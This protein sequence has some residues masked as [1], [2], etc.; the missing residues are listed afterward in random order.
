MTAS[1]L[2][3]H[4][5][6]SQPATDHSSGAALAPIPPPPALAPL[7]GELPPDRNPAAVYLARLAP[8]SRRTMKGAL[9]A[10]AAFVAGVTAERLPW[11]ALRYPH[12]AAI[13]AH[14]AATYAAS[15]ANKMLAALR[16]VLGEAFRLGLM[17]AEDHARASAVE[18]VRGQTVPKGRAVTSGELR[19]LFGACDG[20]SP[21]A[22][23][24][25]AMLAV[26]YGA[27][28]RRAEVA[29]LTRADANGETGALIVRGKGNKERVAY[30]P[31]G[32]LE[33]VGAWLR[34]RGDAPGPLFCPI[35]KGGRIVLRH[36]TEQGVYLALRA[37]ATR[38]GVASFSPH[39][40]R[41]TFIGDLL[42]AGADIATVQRLAGHSSVNTTA[43]YDR[44]GERVKQKAAELL[45]V[46]FVAPLQVPLRAG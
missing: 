37:L 5:P 31:G 30:A 33:A 25:A 18:G 41:R 27:G 40:M 4:P 38:A 2:S 28:L 9:D 20:A 21:I 8:G 44:R 11:Q 45:H 15:T 23:R 26:F 17:T 7:A 35:S 43:R 46:P 19:A 13:R 1:S 36:M 10:I 34:L 6:I 14:L 24:D 22:A 39:D 42:D 29:A 32:A 3:L 12:T 16:G